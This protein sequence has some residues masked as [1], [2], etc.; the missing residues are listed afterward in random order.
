[1]TDVTPLLA[2]AKDIYR[3][4]GWTS[5]LRGTFLFA[6]HLLYVRW[7]QQVYASV[8]EHDQSLSNHNLAPPL[9]DVTHMFLSTNE[10]VDDVEARGY[11]LRSVVRDAGA[12]LDAGAT[13]ACVFVGKEL[14]NVVWV[15]TTQQAMD[16]LKEAPF[17][18]D[19]AGGECW[20]GR[21]WTNPRYRQA[22]LFSYADIKSRRRQLEQGI[23]VSKWA[24]GEHNIPSKRIAA[25]IGATPCAEGRYRRV[26]WWRSWKEIPLGP[27]S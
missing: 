13:A 17:T 8:L 18:V 15:A 20:T 19:F 2:R 23:R 1:M 16:S 25:R 22:G 26:L 14:G 3:T 9:D 7:V 5:L 6:L 24:L 4:E 12:M 21:A 10:E 11:E 27:S